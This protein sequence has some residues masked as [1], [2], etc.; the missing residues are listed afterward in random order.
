MKN[1]VLDS[2]P[3]PVEALPPVGIGRNGGRPRGSGSPAYR[4]LQRT[5]KL[6]PGVPHKIATLKANNVTN[7]KAARRAAASLRTTLGRNY[8]IKVAERMI[9][10]EMVI[11]GTYTNGP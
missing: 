1:L 6:N 5:L 8:G 9:D 4:K 2:N 7:R 3:Q 11:Y 10:G